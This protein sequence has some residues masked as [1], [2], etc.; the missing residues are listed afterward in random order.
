MSAPD[1]RALLI[2]TYELDAAHLERM[3]ELAEAA[4]KVDLATK[5]RRRATRCRWSAM[6]LRKELEART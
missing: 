5:E 4:G 6:S 2:Q 3:A 1:F